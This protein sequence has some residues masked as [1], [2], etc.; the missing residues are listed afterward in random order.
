[1]RKIIIAIMCVLG[2]ATAYAENETQ[3]ATSVGYVAEE[4]ETRQDKFNKLGADT[5]MT[6]SGSTD[7][8]VGSRAI[9]GDLGAETNTS[10]TT[11]PTV[12]GV[13][14]KVANKQ[15][16]L[17]FAANTVLMNTG[18][19]GAPTAKGIYQTSGDYNT[20]TDSLVEAST[21]NAALQTAINSEF[22]CAQRKDP[23]DPT[24]KCLLFNIFAP[25]Q[26]LMIPNTYT[27]LEY[28][29]STGTQWIDTG[30]TPTNNTGVTIDFQYTNTSGTEQLLCGAVGNNFVID[31]VASQ[32]AYAYR[33]GYGL[34]ELFNVTTTELTTRYTATLNWK[35]DGI[36][37][38]GNITSKLNSINFTSTCHF[39]IFAGGYD[40]SSNG[41]NM[42]MYGRVYSTK[43]SNNGSII[44]DFIPARRNSDGELGM[45]DTVSGTFFTNAGTGTFIAGPEI[46]SN[47]YLPMN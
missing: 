27:R 40:R 9:T 42:P 35:N 13:N 12:G 41:V 14:T 19:A 5:A 44:A 21:F 16:E 45:Y 22:T 28:L 46:S 24:S 4:L 23:N 11:L 2:I 31:R 18:V 39:Y 30:I 17:N 47:I 7:G 37:H 36:F 29:E 26:N 38:M 43:L 25:T 34:D 6:Y 15:D 20:Q 3:I 1:M 10:A 33:T 32:F 8:A